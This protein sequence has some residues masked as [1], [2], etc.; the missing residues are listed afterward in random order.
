ME[1]ERILH[2]Y[3]EQLSRK[4]EKKIY[5]KSKSWKS[6]IINE[7]SAS[8][9]KIRWRIVYTK[10]M[11]P[12][13][14]FHSIYVFSILKK[15]ESVK[16][17]FFPIGKLLATGIIHYLN[18]SSMTKKIHNQDSFPI[19]LWIEKY[20]TIISCI[21]ILFPTPNGTII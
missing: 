9:V 16:I 4:N 1:L 21:C 13:K 5:V 19:V 17:S 15:W 8:L 20:N 10:S 6:K 2:K 3:P 14:V 12:I 11:F 18:I 7:C